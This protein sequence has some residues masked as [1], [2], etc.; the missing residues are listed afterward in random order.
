MK[1]LID[2]KQANKDIRKN[3]YAVSDL[4]DKCLAT[5]LHVAYED[6]A[7]CSTTSGIHYIGQAIVNLSAPA[8]DEAGL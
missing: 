6:I 8:S 1:C 4:L 2:S 3:Y 5:Y 7:T